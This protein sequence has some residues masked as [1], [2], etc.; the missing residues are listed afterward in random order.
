ML[1]A[2]G[3]AGPDG[4]TVYFNR[5]RGARVPVPDAPMSMLLLGERAFPP[6]A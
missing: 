5:A 3:E 6:G 2:W 4:S 1:A